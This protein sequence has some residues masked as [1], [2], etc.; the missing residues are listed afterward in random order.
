[1]TNH[2]DRLTYLT[3]SV[4]TLLTALLMCATTTGLMQVWPPP[5]AVAERYIVR[6][7]VSVRP[8]S[9]FRIAT[10][11][12]SAIN[13]RTGELRRPSFESNILCG[14]APWWPS[15]PLNAAWESRD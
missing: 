3:I 2:H 9:N 15:L 12:S 5:G 7:R 6:M 1:M 13:N 11:S 4:L 14:Y 10:W 8:T